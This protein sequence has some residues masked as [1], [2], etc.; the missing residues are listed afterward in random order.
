MSCL[1]MF[2]FSSNLGQTR[3]VENSKMVGASRKTDWD[4]P[5]CWTLGTGFRK[6]EAAGA[7]I[8]TLP[9]ASHLVLIGG[10]PPFCAP[11]ET[12]EVAPP[13][14]F[15]LTK[16]NYPAQQFHGALGST[17]LF[18]CCR[19]VTQGAGKWEL[20]SPEC[21]GLVICLDVL[22]PATWTRNSEY[23]DPCCYPV[24][25]RHGHALPLDEE[26]QATSGCRKRKQGS[27]YS[28]LEAVPRPDVQR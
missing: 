1:F 12:S 2:L 11:Q 25:A 19:M 27:G 8:S 20:Q 4:S 7:G 6:M 16:Q 18:W 22:F 24:T 13:C 15:A 3:D 10:L 5:S 17:F 21:G 26:L 28:W 23:R 9:Y 14:L